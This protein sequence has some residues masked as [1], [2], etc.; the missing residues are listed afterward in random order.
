MIGSAG[1]IFWL[2]LM[3]AFVIFE[4]VTEQLVSIWFAIGSIG[5][6][7]VSGIG[8]PFWLQLVIFLAVSILVLLMGRPFLSSKLHKTKQ[9]TNADRVIGMTGVVLQDI[10]NI[11]E[12]GRVR[13]NGLDWT[14]RSASGVVIPKDAMV[15]VLAIDGVKLIV[16]PVTVQQPAQ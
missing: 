4:G 7:I 6:A 1:V 2:V 12:T 9:P 14:A 3:I 8:G 13:A 16:N 11:R 5:G 10:D 15:T